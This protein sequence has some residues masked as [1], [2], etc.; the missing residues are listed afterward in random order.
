[1]SEQLITITINGD[2]KDIKSIKSVLKKEFDIININ[3]Q[4]LTI[5]PKKVIEPKIWIDLEGCKRI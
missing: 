5:K 2:D 1:M 3:N 4:T